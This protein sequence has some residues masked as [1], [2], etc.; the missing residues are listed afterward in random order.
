MVVV[1]IADAKTNLSHY[2]DALARGER[3]IIAK[4]NRPVAELKPIAAPRTAPRP[5]GGAK[6]AVR[7]PPAFFEPLPDD[8]LDAFE[9]RAQL[10]PASAAPHAAAAGPARAA[11]RRAPGYAGARSR[12]RR[13]KE[14]R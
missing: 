9:G 4:W 13:R 1:N 3:V 8:L 11:E 6:G 5:I 7:V 10:T 14:A 12:R 2:L